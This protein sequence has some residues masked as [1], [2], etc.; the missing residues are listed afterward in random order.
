MNSHSSTQTQSKLCRLPLELMLDIL[1]ATRK[2]SDKIR[3]VSTCWRLYDLLILFVY[4]EAGRQLR[5]LPMFD[6]AKRGNCRTLARCIEAGAPIDYEDSEF[7]F[8]PIRPLQTAIAFARPLTV[9]WLLE[10]G[11]NPNSTRDADR[12]S[13]SCPLAQALGSILRPG[14]SFKSVPY[15]ME[16]RYCKVPSRK[17]Y[18]RNNREI[19]KALRQAGADEQPLGY[20]ERSHLDAIEAGVHCCSHHKP[21]LWCPDW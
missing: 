6:A 12:A 18:V 9:K 13:F 5:W 17:H 16:L 7:P 4:S 3:L 15:Q 8:R 1:D 2:Y 11:A 14:L 19:I 10:H 20:L 21:R